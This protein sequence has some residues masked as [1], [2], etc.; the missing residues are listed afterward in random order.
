[1]LSYYLCSVLLLALGVFSANDTS[2]P[3][4]SSFPAAP[5]D[6]SSWK[7]VDPDAPIVISNETLTIVSP[8][9]SAAER[10]RRVAKQ[11][12]RLA[13]ILSTIR[14]HHSEY[15]EYRA[16]GYE[17]PITPYHIYSHADV[18]LE[19]E[20]RFNKAKPWFHGV[21]QCTRQGDFSTARFNSGRHTITVSC[22]PNPDD[23]SS[24]I[25]G[26]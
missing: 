19:A 10:E 8:G 5:I 11:G 22:I 18:V 23:E 20:V 7:E 3:P 15:C 9:L 12:A 14:E 24:A 16:F 25:T 26:V 1:M 17:C 2:T 4:H 21:V 13:S 6:T